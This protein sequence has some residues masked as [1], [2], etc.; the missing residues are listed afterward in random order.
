VPVGKHNQSPRQLP[1]RIRYELLTG[2][3][4]SAQADGGGFVWV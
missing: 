2:D 4:L 1:D 3:A